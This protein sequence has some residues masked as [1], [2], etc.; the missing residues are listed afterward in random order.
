MRHNVLLKSILRASIARIADSSGYLSRVERQQR[1]TLTI[2]CY[3]RVLPAPLRKA[4]FDPELVVT[5]EMLDLHCAVMARHFEV[6][7]L[8]TGLDDWLSGRESQKPRVA[9]TFDDGYRDNEAYAAPILSSHGLTATFFVV[10]GL[11]GACERTWYDEAGDMLLRLGRNAVL[12]IERAKAMTPTDRQVWLDDLAREAG[13]I[14]LRNDDLIMDETA[15][16]RLIAAGHEIGSHTV[17][18][19]LL[20]Q[21]EGEA[22]RWEIAQSKSDLESKLETTVSGFCYP[23]G[24]LSD[25][26]KTIVDSSGYAYATSSRPGTNRRGDTDRLALRRWFISET[27]LAGRSPQESAALFRF[28]IDGVAHRLFRRGAVT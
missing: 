9:I 19:P 24:N 7:T 17:T 16:Q 26:V 5:P 20:D 4:Y 6:V 1:D 18:H 13:P 14:T 8:G 22:L 27:R 2:V 3:H 28:E 12:E 10:S 11:V 21:L 15:L 23:N 25:A